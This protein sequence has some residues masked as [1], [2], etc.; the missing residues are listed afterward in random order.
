MPKNPKAEAPESDQTPADVEGAVSEAIDRDQEAVD[1][2]E[3]NGFYGRRP[4]DVLN[5]IYTLQG[6][7]SSDENVK[8]ESRV[9]RGE[10]RVQPAP[11][12]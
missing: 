2:A 5:E 3:Q 7:T 4:H 8:A 6:V 11:G 1:E 12:E 10:F 9:N